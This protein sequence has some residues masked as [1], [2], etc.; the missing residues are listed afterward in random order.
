[1][2]IPLHEKRTRFLLIFIYTAE[3]IF[4]SQVLASFE[5]IGLNARQQAMGGTAAAYVNSADA[6]FLNCSGLAMTSAPHFS[7]FYA[8]PFGLKSITHASLSVVLPHKSGF[9]GLAMETFGNNVYQENQYMIS[10]ARS[11]RSKVHYGAAMRL[12]HLDISKYGTDTAVGLDLGFMTALSPRFQWGFYAHNLNRPVI[13]TQDQA[14]PQIFCSGISVLPVDN[15]RMNVDLYKDSKFPAELRFGFEYTF[16]DRLALRSGFSTEPARF[17]AGFGI[18]FSLLQLDYAFQTHND[19]GNTHQFSM[20]VFL[21]KRTRERADK[22]EYQMELLKININT[23]SEEQLQ[24][25]RGIGPTLSRRIVRYRED[26]GP[27]ENIEDLKNV[28]G[29]GDVMFERI[30]DRITTE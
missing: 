1:M 15:A 4:C 9:Y 13:S 30:K 20:S 23:A 16:L 2:H 26:Y 12:M 19:L 24:T 3:L 21:K 8:N 28:K 17:T 7:M 14:I 6:V 10:Y 27:F 18:A 22:I 11:W 5:D 25:L 29:I